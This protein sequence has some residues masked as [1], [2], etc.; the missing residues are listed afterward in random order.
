MEKEQWFKFLAIFLSEFLMMICGAKDGRC[1]AACALLS[2][3]RSRISYEMM[4][5]DQ[6]VS[7]LVIENM[8]FFPVKS[9]EQE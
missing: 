4:M 5:L 2:S 7:F 6:V 3:D 1:A 9:K 8:S